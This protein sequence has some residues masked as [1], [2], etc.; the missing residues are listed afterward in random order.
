MGQVAHGKSHPLIEEG[1][2]LVWGHFSGTVGEFTIL[3]F[4]AAED[5]LEGTVVW[6]IGKHHCCA[7]ITHRLGAVAL[8]ARIAA[9]Q[10]VFAE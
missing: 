5:C 4:A 8:A 6:R 3:G 9:Q 2:E 1:R 7:M 10:A